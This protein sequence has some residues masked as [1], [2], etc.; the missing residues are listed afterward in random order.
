[1]SISDR[2]GALT[3]FFSYFDLNVLWGRYS[4]VLSRNL[5]CLCALCVSHWIETRMRV[6]VEVG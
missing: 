2:G 5:G 4:A 3:F 6:V 1:M